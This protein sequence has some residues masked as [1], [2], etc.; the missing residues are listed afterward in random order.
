MKQRYTEE[1]IIGFPRE[2]DDRVAGQGTA[3]EARPPRAELLRWKAKFG[4]KMVLDAQRLRN[5]PVP[6]PT[7]TSARGT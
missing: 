6:V 1:Q 3:Q 4:G 7:F 2:V 5:N